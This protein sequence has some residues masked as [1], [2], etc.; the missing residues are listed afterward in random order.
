MFAAIAPS[1]P[2]TVVQRKGWLQS[3]ATPV[4]HFQIRVRTD[5][6]DTSWVSPTPV[7]IWN[8]AFAEYRG[9]RA[10]EWWKR[11]FSMG[12]FV[13]LSSGAVIQGRVGYSK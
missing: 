7:N 5:R 8:R 11:G 6:E 3:E 10:R 4:P 2:L 12:D 1:C 13:Q 9:E